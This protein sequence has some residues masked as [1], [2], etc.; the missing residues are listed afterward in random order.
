MTKTL[1]QPILDG[2][3]TSIEVKKDAE[4]RWITKIDRELEGSVFSAGCSNWYIN[5]AGRNSA[6]WPGYASTFWWKT[7]FPKFSDFEFKGGK[8][9]AAMKAVLKSNKYLI[10]VLLVVCGTQMR[11]RIA[12]IARFLK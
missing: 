2:R 1:F 7:F 10:L 5:S 8:P 6:S 11:N 4:V 12:R 9:F 3:A